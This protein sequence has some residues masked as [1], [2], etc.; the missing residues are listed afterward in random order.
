MSTSNSTS[1]RVIRRFVLF[2][3]LAFVAAA[4]THFGILSAAYRHRPAGTAEGVIGIVLLIGW[5]ST[6]IRP[7]STR[8]IGVTVQ[9]FALFGTLVG[10]FTII[11]G[12]GPRTVPDIT[13]H[14][15]IVVALVWGLAAAVRM[16]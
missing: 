8:M 5:V 3:G 4:L 14:A 2:E 11:V 6:S 10:I 1:T 7:R 16:K 15:V 9:A 13:Y 12:V